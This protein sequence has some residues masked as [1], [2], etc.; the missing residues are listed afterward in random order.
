MDLNIEPGP[1]L[2]RVM[3]TLTARN[4]W[5]PENLDGQPQTTL[6]YGMGQ[7]ATFDMII[8]SSRFIRGDP[9]VQ[10]GGFMSHRLHHSISSMKKWGGQVDDYL[11]VHNWFDASRVDFRDMRHRSIRHHLE[12]FS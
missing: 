2:L 1:R 7:M 8:G 3:H 4:E 11:P 6:G 10:P 9:R 5:Q 12:G